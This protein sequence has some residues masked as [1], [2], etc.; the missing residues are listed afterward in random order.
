MQRR[1][2][3]GMQRRSPA[4]PSKRR[5]PAAPGPARPRCTSAAPRTPAAPQL[6]RRPIAHSSANFVFRSALMSV[7]CAAGL[8]AEQ[9][10]AAGVLMKGRRV[11]NRCTMICLSA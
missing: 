10:S 1:V 5:R 7:V 4:A 8:S 6:G 11:V 3:A 2:P 9:T